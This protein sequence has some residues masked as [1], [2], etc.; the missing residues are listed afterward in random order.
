MII[1]LI[2]IK[3]MSL[4]IYELKLSAEANEC[5]FKWKIEPQYV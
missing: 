3:I 2:H 5:I 1:Q 4:D